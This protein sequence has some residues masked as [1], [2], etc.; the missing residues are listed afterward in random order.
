MSMPAEY[1]EYIERA[2]K[3]DNNPAVQEF[4]SSYRGKKAPLSAGSEYG[5]SK[6]E[7][8]IFDIAPGL[9]R[10]LVARLES[11]EETFEQE[12]STLVP[13]P[14]AEIVDPASGKNFMTI[15]NELA[16]NSQRERQ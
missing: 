14:L 4:I 3:Y 2:Q 16:T 9:G 6:E 12:S 11:I 5:T 10:A 13:L 7:V 1:R 8:L 15:I